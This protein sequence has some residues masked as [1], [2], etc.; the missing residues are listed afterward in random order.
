ML[1]EG[2]WRI[3]LDIKMAISY[4]GFKINYWAGEKIYQVFHPLFTLYKLP[5]F[6]TLKGAKRWIDKY[7]REN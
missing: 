3:C 6:K 1:Q 4:K 2:T 7:R 5:T